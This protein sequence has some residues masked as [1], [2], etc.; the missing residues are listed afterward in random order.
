MPFHR[1]YDQGD[2]LV[3]DIR[4]VHDRDRIPRPDDDLKGGVTVQGASRRRAAIHRVPLADGEARC[5]MCFGVHVLDTASRTT[6]A[7]KVRAPDPSLHRLG[8]L[9]TPFEAE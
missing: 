1:W 4:R 5:R 8:P 9:H 6:T 3:S 7:C 2:R